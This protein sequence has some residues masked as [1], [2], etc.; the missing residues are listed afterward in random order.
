MKSDKRGAI[1]TWSPI[2]LYLFATPSRFPVKLLKR[3]LTHTHT[4]NKEWNKWWFVHQIIALSQI[5]FKKNN[6]FISARQM[7]QY[8]KAN[9]FLV[10]LKTTF[11]AFHCNS[12]F[13]YKSFFGTSIQFIHC[14]SFLCLLFPCECFD[15]A[16]HQGIEISNWKS[17]VTKIGWTIFELF[18]KLLWHILLHTY[19]FARFSIKERKAAT[20]MW[21]FK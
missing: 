16:K 3:T 19:F 1:K 21:L 5:L 12:S 9:K 8:D 15:S 14:F 11:I 17:F 13:L 7:R 20:I 6:D 10:Y 4:H 2:F 18:E